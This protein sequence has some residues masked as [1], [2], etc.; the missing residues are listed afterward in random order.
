MKKY[1][2]HAQ[3]PFSYPCYGCLYAASAWY[4]DRRLDI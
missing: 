4:N 2:L 3:F 1:F